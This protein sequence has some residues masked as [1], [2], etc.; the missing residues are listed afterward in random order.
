MTCLNPT[1]L[2]DDI[3]LGNSN[4]VDWLSLE[5]SFS[6]SDRADHGEELDDSFL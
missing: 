1:L 5:V 3:F 6:L 2:A 4:K